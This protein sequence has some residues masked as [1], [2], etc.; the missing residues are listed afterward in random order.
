[1]ADL[2]AKKAA[3]KPETSSAST[4]AFDG[5]SDQELSPD[6]LKQKYAHLDSRPKS[7]TLSRDE[8]KQA[9]VAYR[10]LPRE[11][12]LILKQLMKYSCG[13]CESEFK[14]PNVGA[15]HG[16]C[17][18]H[19]ADMYKKMGRPAPAVKSDSNKRPVDLSILSKDE[20]QLAVRLF[21]ILREKDKGRLA[22]RTDIPPMKAAA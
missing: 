3:Q 5:R 6:E 14:V 22:R 7:P 16:Y 4:L 15:S 21:A 17:P 1:M 20:L 2:A 11:R 12:Q 13:M 9:L 8:A 18:R 10:Q 19:L